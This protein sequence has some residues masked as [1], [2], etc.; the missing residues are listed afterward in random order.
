MWPG[1]CKLFIDVLDGGTECTPSKFADYANMRGIASRAGGCAAVHRDLHRQE[2]CINIPH[3]NEE[4]CLVL[5]LGRKDS[6][7]P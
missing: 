4:K 1:L 6:P 2:K 5:Q 3:E 7:N